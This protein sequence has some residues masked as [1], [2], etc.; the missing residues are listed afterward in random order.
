TFYVH[1]AVLVTHSG[2]FRA[3]VKS[4][5]RTDPTKPIDLTDECA[6]V[7]NIYVLWLYTGEIGFLTPTTLFYEAQVTLAHAYVL[8]AKLHDPAFRNAVVSALFTFLKK[9]KKD[10]A[11]NAFIKVVYVGTAKGA[12]ARRLAIDA[13]A[14]RGHSKFSGL[15]NLVEETCVEF[16]HDVLKEVLK[17]RPDTRS[18]NVWEKEPERY[19]VKDDTNED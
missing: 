8:G 17:I 1:E 7:F 19:F 4:E 12:P 15:E 14:T 16:V 2:F 3:A 9:N 10:C 5:W 13:W 6:S 11:C 18:D